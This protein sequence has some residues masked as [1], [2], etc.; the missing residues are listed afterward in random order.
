VEAVT[1]SFISDGHARYF[2]GGAPALRITNPISSEMTDMRPSLLPGLLA[3]ARGNAHRGF[4]DAAL[5]E[6]GQI[7]RGDAPED[8]VNAAS[9]V[10]TG[11]VRFGGGGRHWDGAAKAVDIF[12]VK[13]DAL[14]VLE[15]LGLDV[16]KVQAA[17]NAPAWFH[18][19]RSGA[20]Q[21]GPKTILAHFGELHPE[22]LKAMDL[23]GAVAAFEVFLDAVPASRRK[24]T[25]KGPLIASDFQPVKR[26]F[27]FLA[28]KAVEAA[29][30]LR[31]AEGADKCLISRVSIFD[32][33]EGQGVPEGKKS[34]AVEIT[35]TPLQGT[36]TD[37][38][39]E[40]VSAKVIAQVKRATGAEL[41]G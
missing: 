8:Q 3:A 1:W 15:A 27:A 33:F 5:F 39:I 16:T 23:E 29:A 12:D 7:F 2:G 11:T 31:A 25:A 41:R 37:A 19:G 13:A 34:L 9:G 36:L 21:L 24:G 6:A 38:E 4:Q 18:P 14:A 28:D 10:R 32:I 30:V 20:L 40:A 35:L 26:D 17:R 22:T